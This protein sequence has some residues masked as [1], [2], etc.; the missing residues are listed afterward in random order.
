MITCFFCGKE[1]RK[2]H[3]VDNGL[4]FCDEHCAD[5]DWRLRGADAY[6][7]EMTDGFIGNYEDYAELLGA[8]V[9]S[10]YAED[11]LSYLRSREQ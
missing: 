7:A 1:V 8:T 11:Q 4:H 2:R 3:I 5:N 10:H 6:A 9:I